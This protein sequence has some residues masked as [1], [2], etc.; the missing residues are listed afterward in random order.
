[1][2]IDTDKKLLYFWTTLKFYVFDIEDPS[3]IVEQ[4]SNLFNN[5]LTQPFNTQRCHGTYVKSQNRI[6]VE[7][8]YSL[9]YFTPTDVTT[10][11]CIFDY[12]YTVQKTSG[13]TAYGDH[14]YYIGNYYNK[15]SGI[16]YAPVGR[17]NLNQGNLVYNPSEASSIDFSIS[18]EGVYLDVSYTELVNRLLRY[19][20]FKGNDSFAYYFFNMIMK[21]GR[22]Y[23]NTNI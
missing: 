21:Q 1:M 5:L 18:E 2:E 11:T 7:D 16:F 20:V 10:F 3:Y 13:V 22:V 4:A 17:S 19:E 9:C 8:E 6:Y 15:G 12:E 23:R 14:I